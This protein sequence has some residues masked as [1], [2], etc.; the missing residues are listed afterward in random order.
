MPV[1]IY[2]LSNYR[3][4]RYGVIS[5]AEWFDHNNKSANEIRDVCMNAVVSDLVTFLQEN[6]SG[7]AILDATN[8]TY[9]RRKDLTAKV[10]PIYSLDG[11]QYIP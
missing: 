6:S 7:V 8:P 9:E 5:E 2:N 4:E 1:Q 11:D 3:R 10:S